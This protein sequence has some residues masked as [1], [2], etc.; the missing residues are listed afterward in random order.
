MRWRKGRKDEERKRR[1]GGGEE[2][3]SRV[4]DEGGRGGK[5]EG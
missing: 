5:E 1:V 4:R 3:W 2:E